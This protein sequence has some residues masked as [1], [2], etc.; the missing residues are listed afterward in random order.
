MGS[1]EVES[2]NGHTSSPHKKTV[3]FSLKSQSP[4]SHIYKTMIFWSIMHAKSKIRNLIIVLQHISIYTLYYISSRSASAFSHFHHPFAFY[5]GVLSLFTYL[6]CLLAEVV[7]TYF[8]IFA[9]CASVVVNLDKDKVVTQPGISIVWGLT[10][11]VLVYS[12]GHISGAHFNPAVTIAHATTK[13]FPL[14]QVSVN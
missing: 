2:T 6:I 11:M 12:V 4:I 1:L 10:V 7:G 5:F 13:R 8:L 9:G 3:S 14:K